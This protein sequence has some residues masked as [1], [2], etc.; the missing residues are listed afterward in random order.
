MKKNAECRPTAAQI[1]ARFW[2]LR[3]DKG[4]WS[5]STRNSNR[6]EAAL[7]FFKPCR[8]FSG[9]GHTQAAACAAAMK[10]MEARK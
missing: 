7:Y 8:K 3:C 1:I 6:I 9:R 10:Q 5:D 2:R 4:I